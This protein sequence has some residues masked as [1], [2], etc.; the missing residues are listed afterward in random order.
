MLH[1][2]GYDEKSI[3]DTHKSVQQ[4][5]YKSTSSDGWQV[6]NYVISPFE[7]N[8]D[9]GDPHGITL[10]I[11]TTKEKDTE[12]DKLDISVPNSKDIIDHL[13]A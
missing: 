1:L 3:K 2:N 12:A 9:T 10:Y 6:V 4:P 11:E 7:E 5:I 13:S 8:I